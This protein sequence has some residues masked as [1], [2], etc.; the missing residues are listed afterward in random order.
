MN[1][2]TTPGNSSFRIQGHERNKKSDG[3]V[4]NMV[5][6]VHPCH[7]LKNEEERLQQII[8][9]ITEES[10]RMVVFRNM[11]EDV[12]FE[13]CNYSV[14]QELPIKLPVNCWLHGQP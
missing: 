7:R 1:Y 8:L 12:Q 4:S 2:L 14:F 10:Q 3:D 6:V 9:V 11:I 5:A 13:L